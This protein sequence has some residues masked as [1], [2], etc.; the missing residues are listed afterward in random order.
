MKTLHLAMVAALAVVL[1]TGCQK[2]EMIE[3]ETKSKSLPDV[4]PAKSYTV[5]VENVSVHYDYFAAGAEFGV[6]GGDATPPAHPGES[7]MVKFHAGMGHKLSFATMYGASNDWF[8]GPKDDGIE[9]FPGGS[10]LEGDITN[11]VYLWD[12]GT[13]VDGSTTDEEESEPVS[14]VPTN[15]QNIQVLLDYDGASMF[16]LTVNVLPGSATPLSPLAWVVHSMN[17]FPIFTEGMKDYGMGLEVVAE[18]G[19]AGPLG[20][21]L[22]MNSGYVSPIAPVLWAVHEKGEMPLFT[23]NT[24]DRGEGLEL[25]AETG[26]PGDLVANLVSMNYQAGAQAIPY[27][28]NSPGPIFPGDKYSFSIDAKPGQ[29]LSIA[30]MLGNSND[31]FFAFADSGI[32]LNFG[33]AEQSITH[34]VMLWDAGT[35]VNQYPGTKYMNADEGGLVRLVDDGFTYPDVDKM[36]K[37]TIYKNKK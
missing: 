6:V 5:M 29:Y 7:I 9:L 21:Y 37:V 16:T 28:K 30:S 15:E 1:F 25:L 4:V 24:P 32:K 34:E 18:T 11:M 31:L 13:E 27:G 14:M 2:E 22:E 8:Y 12:A 36:I 33:N 23:N 35:A 3:V 10:A 19:N 17:Q 26:N 20:E